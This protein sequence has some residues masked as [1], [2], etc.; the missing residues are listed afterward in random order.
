MHITKTPFRGDGSPT[1]R[2][3]YRPRGQPRTGD[4]LT[5]RGDKSPAVPVPD[6]PASALN[7]DQ[8]CGGENHENKDRNPSIAALTI[9]ILAVT[10]LAQAT[11][12]PVNAQSSLLEEFRLV[13]AGKNG[14]RFQTTDRLI[15]VSGAP[16]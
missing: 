7:T 10:L 4:S 5:L 8:S 2:H 16:W 9:G 3:E 13:H 14:N 11:P 1:A 12:Q 6:C 15:N